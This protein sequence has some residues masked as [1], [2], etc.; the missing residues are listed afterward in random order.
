MV[1]RARHECTFIRASLTDAL[2]SHHACTALSGAA[3]FLQKPQK[4]LVFVTDSTVQCLYLQ[5]KLLDDAGDQPGEFVRINC[6]DESHRFF[7][8][9]WKEES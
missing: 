5:M 6:V 1:N 3:A 2:I 9:V 8:A 4:P 7:Y